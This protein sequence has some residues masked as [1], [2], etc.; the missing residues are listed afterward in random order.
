MPGALPDEF[1][2][3]IRSPAG[4]GWMTLPSFMYVHAPV[5]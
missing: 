3:I 2:V 4:N 5:L 1:P